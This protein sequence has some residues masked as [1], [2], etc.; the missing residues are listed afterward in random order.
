M[1]VF[2]NFGKNEDYTPIC[3]LSNGQYLVNFDKK[4]QLQE[5]QIMQNS[6]LVGT[7]KLL[8]TGYSSW[9]YIVF[10]SKPS[11]VAIQ[12][13]IYNIINKEVSACIEDG[14]IWNGYNVHLSLENQMN[15]KNAF[16]LAITTSGESLPVTFK[17]AKNGHSEYYTFDNISELKAFYIAV[18]NHINKCLE[19]GWKKKDKFNKEE[20]MLSNI[21]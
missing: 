2:N 4:E 3:K 19:N 21:L 18:N 13:T 6:R 14:L 10:D 1:N 8:P 7:G 11:I 20:Y 9:R 15:Y 16:D 17:F 5:E 12:D